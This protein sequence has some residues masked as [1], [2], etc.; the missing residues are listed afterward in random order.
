MPSMI[1]RTVFCEDHEI[2]RDAVRRFIEQEITPH[3]RKWED[4]GKVSREIWLKAGAAGFLCSNVP[5]EY[6]GAGADFKYNA[7]FTEE[8]GRAGITGPGFAIHSDMVAAY[9][10]NFANDEQKSKW[11]PKMARGEVIAALGLTEP[12]AGSDLK[13]IKTTAI[14]EGDHYVINGQKTYISNGQMCDIVVLACKTDVS[15]GAK[16]MTFIIVEADRPGFERGRNLEKLGLKAQDTSEL[17][18]SDV[19][20]PVSNRIGNEGQGFAIAMHNLAEERLSIAVS[21]LG[22]CEGILDYTITYTKERAV[23]GQ[24]VSDFQNTR[25]KISELSAQLQSHRVF[26][27][28]CVELSVAKQLDVTTAAMAKM[29]ATELQCKVADECLQFYGGNGYMME[30][31]IAHAYLD[32]RIRRIAG[33]SSEVMREIISRKVFA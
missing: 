18:F 21:A 25:F 14:L 1:A 8:L 11:L 30:Y 7:V 4:D 2:Y 24:M 31:Q 12:G 27:D 33:G 23:F 6:G 3:H 20:V 13:A 9:I 15:A 32:A 28:H 19:R 5:E 17:F 26:V 22:A 10:T 29:L 16:G